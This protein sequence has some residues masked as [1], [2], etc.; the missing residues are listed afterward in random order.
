MIS[1]KTEIQNQSGKDKIVIANTNHIDI[2]RE[3]IY[4]IIC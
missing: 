3:G 1:L 4:D 2:R